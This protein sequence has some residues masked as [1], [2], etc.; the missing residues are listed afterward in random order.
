MTNDLTFEHIPLKKSITSR[1]FRIVFS[2]YFF[3]TLCLTIFQMVTEY[4]HTKQE[5]YREI[6]LLVATIEP[7][8]GKSIWDI[9]MTRAYSVIDIISKQSLVE[10]VHV[11]DEKG[12]LILSAPNRS[13]AL[14]QSDETN[15]QGIDHQENSNYFYNF[16]IFHPNIQ[17]KIGM[18]TIYFSQD[19]VLQRVKYGFIL[20]IINSLLKTLALWVIFSMVSQKLLARPLGQLIELIR[21]INFDNLEQLSVKIKSKSYDELKIF[22][23]T[24]NKMVKNLIQ[25]RREITENA[26]ELEENNRKLQ[27]MDQLKDEFLANTSHELRTPLHGVIGIGRSLKEYLAKHELPEVQSNLTMLVNIGKHLSRLVNDIL[28]FS[29]LKHHT[30]QIHPQP[31]DVK[32]IFGIVVQIFQPLITDKNLLIENELSDDLPLV[33]ADENRLQQVFQNLISN[34]IKYTDRGVIRIDAKQN[35]QFLEISIYTPNYPIPPQDY[36]TIFN[37]FE[38]G[39]G[40]IERHR[41]GTGLGLAIVK[42]LVELHGGSISVHSGD[43]IG[44]CFTFSLPISTATSVSKQMSKIMEPL[45]IT[46]KTPIPLYKVSSEEN[47]LF[48][49]L[50]VDDDITNLQVV[51]NYLTP[52]G[53]S[54]NCVQSGTEAL[55]WIETN[56]I[57]DLILLDI[58]MPQMSGFDVCRILRQKH[59]IET[60]PILFLTASHRR[61]DVETGFSLG[62]NDYLTKPFEKRELL[63]R[64]RVHL[65]SLL[66]GRQMQLLHDCANQ[67]SEFKEREQM[68]RFAVDQLI[69]S[70]LVSDAV[71]FSEVDC[72]HPEVKKYKFLEKHPPTEVLDHY[73]ENQDQR[74]ILINSIK[75]KDP[76]YQFYSDQDDNEELVGGNLIFL[77]PECCQESIICLFRGR[78]RMP[79]SELDKEFM[80]SLMDQIRTIER[81][82]Q[83]MLSDQLVQALPVIQPSLTRISHIS[84]VSPYCHIY[85]EHQ[86][87]PKEVRISLS[88]LDL[89][90]NDT[91]LLRIHRSY[92]INPEKIIEIKKRF[93][94]SKKYRYEAIIGTKSNLFF[95]RIGDSYIKKLKRIFPQYFN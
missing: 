8:L 66:A 31:L 27:K 20:I 32:Q 90:F 69:S 95:L 26:Q 35:D 1:L 50:V 48:N 22:E 78:A 46:L 7:V 91:S 57:P 72:Y 16:E 58:M 19:A 37:A 29:K 24:L 36:Q 80:S 9:D 39:N 88:N 63:S 79:F 38:Q 56:G 40:S 21:Q 52:Y 4:N 75:Q 43:T 92:L 6:K 94:G 2:I 41:G 18:G 77:M 53:Y 84:A 33:L 87:E 59:P 14:N 45:P 83:S 65:K 61:K 60:L 17:T 70:R 11:A 49:L 30:L 74:L 62:A 10:K 64:I 12:N 3:V 15:Q 13:L 28:D 73:I 93:V 47:S 81:N 86:S 89:Y 82:I 34:A 85:F 67:I 5:I 54:I 25:A 76:I 23:T 51:V 55:T 71:L 42:Q 68:L 44:N